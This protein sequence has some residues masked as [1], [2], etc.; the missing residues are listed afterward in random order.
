MKARNL[1]CQICQV[2]RKHEIYKIGRNKFAR[3]TKCDTNEKLD[4]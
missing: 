4:F 3:C 2:V 1:F